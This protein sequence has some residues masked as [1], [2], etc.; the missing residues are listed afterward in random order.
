[1]PNL[2]KQQNGTECGVYTIARIR[3]LIHN[4]ADPEELIQ[5]RNTES[6][7]RLFVEEIRAIQLNPERP[8]F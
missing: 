1:M 4:W 8:R 2:S 6:L 7:R 3:G 5:D